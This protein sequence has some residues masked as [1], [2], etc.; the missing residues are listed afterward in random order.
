M[1]LTHIRHRH[2]LSIIAAVSSLLF[3]CVLPNAHAQAARYCNDSLVVNAAYSNLNSNG[4]RAT[5]TYFV[6]IQNLANHSQRYN[7]RFTAP[8]ILEA[9]NGSNFFSLAP[10]QQ[11][12]VT[13]GKRQVNNPSGSGALT[14]NEALK[15]VQIVCR[16]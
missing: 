6:Q 10:Y 1:N 14:P 16:P 8:L 11:G 9:Q 13:L 3:T 4:S 2:R 5:V 7:L 12:T 15:F